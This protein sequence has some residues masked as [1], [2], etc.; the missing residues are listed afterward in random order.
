MATVFFFALTPRFYHASP[1]LVC[2]VLLSFVSIFLRREYHVIVYNSRGVG[3]SGGSASWTGFSEA[4][5]L[6][7]VVDLVLR[8]IEAV[9]EIVLLV[10]Q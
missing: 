1:R 6:Q 5:D 4:Q 2:S 8:E 7:V 10:R 9:D 3:N